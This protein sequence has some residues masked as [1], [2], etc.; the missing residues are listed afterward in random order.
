MITKMI[1]I[2][3]VTSDND[4]T[5]ITTIT[6]ATTTTNT[7]YN[8]NINNNNYNTEKVP[9]LISLNDTD[10]TFHNILYTPA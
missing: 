8:N 9:V 10:V 7:T 6:N 3:K 4:N 1:V 5:A 2:L